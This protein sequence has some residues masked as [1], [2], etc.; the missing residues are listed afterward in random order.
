MRHSNS[1]AC[2]GTEHQHVK[3]AAHRFLPRIFW[4]RFLAHGTFLQTDCHGGMPAKP[5]GNRVSS[6]WHASIVGSVR[7]CSKHIPGSVGVQASQIRMNGPDAG[8]KDETAGRSVEEPTSQS[9]A[10][11]A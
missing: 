10:E 9:S 1:D 6:S 8:C 3:D 4:R 7:W 5:S 11:H 2:S